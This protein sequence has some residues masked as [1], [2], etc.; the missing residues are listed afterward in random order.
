M[1][2]K[3]QRLDTGQHPKVSSGPL[4]HL[5]K[6]SFHQAET[7]NYCSPVVLSAVLL[8]YKGQ[9]LEASSTCP[10][11]FPLLGGTLAVFLL[12]LMVLGFELRAYTLSR[13]PSPLLEWDFWRQGLR[14]CFPGLSLNLDPPDLVTGSMQY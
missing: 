8:P 14:N 10:S 3:E 1:D 5:P 11:S 4:G 2:W 6:N 9:S 12:F 7:R 13:S